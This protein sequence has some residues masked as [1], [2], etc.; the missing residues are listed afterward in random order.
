M[1]NIKNQVTLIGNLGSDMEFKTF[2]SA[3]KCSKA[4]LATNQY[5]KNRDGELVKE[6]QWHNLVAWGKLAE[7]MNNLAKKGDQI[8]VQGKISYRNYEDV[9]GKKHYITEIIVNEFMKIGKP[10][11][12][13]EE[14]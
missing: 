10:A 14:N 8:L 7:L 6:T 4:S 12:V 5:Y 1:N 11:T 9:D 2:D 13:P 3:K